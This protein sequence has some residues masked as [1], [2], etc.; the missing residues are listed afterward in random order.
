[1]TPAIRP[2]TGTE[3]TDKFIFFQF[4]IDADALKLASRDI[5]TRLAELEE[6]PWD[7][8]RAGRALTPRRLASIVRPYGIRP[9]NI[10]LEH[11]TCKGYD[12]DQF[13]DAWSRYLPPL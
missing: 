13:R 6:R 12:F 8:Y 7:E 2:K 5:C 11:Y 3:T 1:M 9:K 4:F 10:R